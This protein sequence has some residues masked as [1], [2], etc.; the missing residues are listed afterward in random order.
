MSLRH[1]FQLHLGRP[2]LRLGIIQPLLARAVFILSLNL[3]DNQ[4]LVEIFQILHRARDEGKRG[5]FS[6]QKLPLHSFFL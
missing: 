3:V 6:L 1:L 4:L 2:Q 5:C